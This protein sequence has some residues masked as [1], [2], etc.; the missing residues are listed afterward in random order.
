[1]KP[2]MMMPLM[3]HTTNRLVEENLADATIGLLSPI[4]I[5]Q[6]SPSS[7]LKFTISGDDADFFEIDE[8][9]TLKLKSGT[10]VDYESRT[11]FNVLYRDLGY[12]IGSD[13][14]TTDRHV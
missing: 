11:T 4:N 1:M 7:S 8:L 13:S 12:Y 2:L 14:Y 3:K 6:L 10:V 5:N 9:G